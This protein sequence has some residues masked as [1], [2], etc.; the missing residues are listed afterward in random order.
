MTQRLT[1]GER[2]D[3]VTI[4][5]AHSMNQSVSIVRGAIPAGV[6]PSPSAVPD[7]ID[8]VFVARTTMSMEPRSIRVVAVGEYM[9]DYSFCG[10][11]IVGTALSMHRGPVLIVALQPGR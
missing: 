5:L 10:A 1:G 11:E 7:S 2:L 9:D 6:V 8:C 4:T 3:V